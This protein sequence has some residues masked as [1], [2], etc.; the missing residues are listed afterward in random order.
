MNKI[1]NYTLAA[2]AALTFSNSVM[3]QDKKPV[4]ADENAIVSGLYNGKSIYNRLAKGQSYILNSDPKLNDSIDFK[5]ITYDEYVKRT[6]NAIK[7]VS[8]IDNKWY[9]RF[10][11]WVKDHKEQIQDEKASLELSQKSSYDK[12]SACDS[13]IIQE[14]NNVLNNIDVSKIKGKKARTKGITGSEDTEWTY[15]M[16]TELSKKNAAS[17]G[18]IIPVAEMRY[19]MIKG[20]KVI[21]AE[22]SQLFLYQGNHGGGGY[23][24]AP[25]STVQAKHEQSLKQYSNTLEDALK[26]GAKEERKNNP[27][28]NG[29]GGN[30]TIVDSYNTTNITI[31][32][33]P[34]KKDSVITPKIVAKQQSNNVWYLA[35]G[36]EKDAKID[37]YVPQIAGGFRFGRASIGIVATYIKYTKNVR[38]IFTNQPD[39]TGFSNGYTDEQEDIN[40]ESKGIGGEF[41]IKISKHIDAWF[42]TQ[43]RMNSLDTTAEV[44]QYDSDKVWSRD[45]TLQFNA[46][47]NMNYWQNSLGL[48][49]DVKRLGL[50]AGSTIEKNPSVFVDVIYRFG[51]EK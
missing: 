3:A 2:L 17:E 40:I 51:K 41:G 1:M 9:N 42:R 28:E 27:E 36:M 8:A 26:S 34:E 4:P 15:L 30:N 25:K 5:V 31:V 20:K 19:S 50:R 12:L 47:G 10:N 22:T 35:A 13:K 33:Q 23:K 43:Y 38:N 39:D 11:P 6:K 48:E 44:H 37:L 24:T 32:N 21:V 7:N 14:G 18:L 49:L 16:Q 29:Q 46:H 45:E